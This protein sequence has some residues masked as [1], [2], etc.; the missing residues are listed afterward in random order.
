LTSKIINTPKIFVLCIGIV[1]AVVPAV[2]A[3]QGNTV[4]SG[5][6][7][8][9]A[10]SGINYNVLPAE[11]T[12]ISTDNPRISSLSTLYIKKGGTTYISSPNLGSA[13]NW[14][15]VDLKWGNTGNSLDLTIYSPSGSCLGTYYDKS[16]GRLDGRTHLYIYPSTRYIKPGKWKFK[17]YGASVSGTQSY[18]LNCYTH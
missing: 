4:K 9:K 14:L 3:S 7:L 5:T 16:D 11:E 2:S 17:V 18:T 12:A 1:L 13:V 6:E 8:N 10:A 15:E